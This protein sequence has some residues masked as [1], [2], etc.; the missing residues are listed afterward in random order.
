MTTHEHAH[1]H[2]HQEV[3]QM[4]G[5]S[6]GAVFVEV[7]EGVGAAV[8][9]TGPEL[10]G[11]EIE[12]RPASGEWRGQHTAVRE[13]RFAG[14]VRCAAVFGSLA[15]GEWELRVRG[16]TDVRP[17]LAIRVPGASVVEAAW[18]GGPG[19]PGERGR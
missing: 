15:E 19:E 2:T 8:I 9:A 12:I 18:P 11:S 7:G 10:D 13:R 1:D 6:E 4:P 14:T 16:S 3:E 5:P 17:V